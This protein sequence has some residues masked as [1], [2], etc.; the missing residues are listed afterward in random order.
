MVDNDN[1]RSKLVKLIT[2]RLP[3]AKIFKT[4]DCCT[5]DESVVV[6]R[7]IEIYIYDVLDIPL[8]SVE[9]TEA[10]HE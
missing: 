4:K 7:D 1:N 5:D 8:L 9:R 3:S 6:Y 2:S 10:G